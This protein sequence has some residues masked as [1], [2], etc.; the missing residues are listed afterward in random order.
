MLY[1]DGEQ[2]FSRGT[3]ALSDGNTLAA[4]VHFE[5]AVQA[6]SQPRYLSYLGYC[7]ALQRGQVQKGIGL[8]RQS[9]AEEPGIADHYLNLG[10]ILLV[11]GNKVEALE[12]LREGMTVAPH[13]E[14]SA[15]LESIGNRKPPVIGFLGRD[16]LINKYLGLLLARLGL[17]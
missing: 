10:R 4:L 11:A 8:C 3:A 14:I 12:V 5:K 15:L 2:E 1:V 7:A 17:R 9:M 13:P 6:A 16:N